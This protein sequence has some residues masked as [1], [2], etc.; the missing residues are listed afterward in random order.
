MGIFIRSGFVLSAELILGLLGVLRSPTSWE[1]L[2]PSRSTGLALARRWVRLCCH[3]DGNG[4]RADAV[5]NIHEPL[6][7]YKD[8]V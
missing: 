1:E 4:L 5:N 7:K 2:S 8:P 3:R 6:A